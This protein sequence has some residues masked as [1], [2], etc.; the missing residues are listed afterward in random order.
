M[1]IKNKTIPEVVIGNL[2]FGKFVRIKLLDK[3][4]KRCKNLCVGFLVL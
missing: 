1:G 3:N 2:H 4:V